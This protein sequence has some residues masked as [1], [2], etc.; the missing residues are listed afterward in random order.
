MDRVEVAFGNYWQTDK[1]CHR[2]LQWFYQQDL[3]GELHIALFGQPNIT[4]NWE[5][6]QISGKPN[7]RNEE[8][9]SVIYDW[10]AISEKYTSSPQYSSFRCMCFC[11]CGSVNRWT[12]V[13]CQYNENIYREKTSF[14]IIVIKFLSVYDPLSCFFLVLRKNQCVK[15]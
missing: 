13:R 5:Q 4:S 6:M 10:E 12:L 14:Q 11:I 7:F 1:P 8:S 9:R 2:N 3:G 15:L